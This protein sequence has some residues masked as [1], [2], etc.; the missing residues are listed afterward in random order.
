MFSNCYLSINDFLEKSKRNEHTIFNYLI[1]LMK[2][3]SWEKK[4]GSGYC[5]YGFRTRRPEVL[6]KTGLQPA[7]FFK[8][9]FNCI[10]FASD[11]AKT[12]KQALF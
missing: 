7:K 4:T 9:R 5:L 10:D 6:C 3:V 8:Y 2:N 11:L 12:V 1:K